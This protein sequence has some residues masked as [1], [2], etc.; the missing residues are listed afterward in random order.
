MK[1][2]EI[3]EFY[4]EFC[5]TFAH[6]KRFEIMDL[7]KGREMTVTDIQKKIGAS[8]AYTSQQLIVMRMKGV[9][10]TRRQGQSMYYGI[11]SKK[12][13]QACSLMQ[14]GLEQ[15]F[16]GSRT[17]KRKGVGSHKGEMG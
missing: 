13:S 10:K 15:L 3:L 11:A 4:A 16:S 14:E 5:K 6:P 12:V 9:L 8:K 17:V 1:K 7:L 2:K